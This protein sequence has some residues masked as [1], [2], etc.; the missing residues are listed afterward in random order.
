MNEVDYKLY[1]NIVA[2]SLEEIIMKTKNDRI[3]IKDFDS[4]DIYNKFVFQMGLIV[5]TVCND[6]YKYV[7]LDMNPIKYFFYCLR[8]KKY[9][10]LIKRKKELMVDDYEIDAKEFCK[11][12]CE[13]FNVS[14]SIIHDIYKEY[15]K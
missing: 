13:K 5:S 12:L 1:D 4:L 3:L 8:H 14:I 2:S 7:C 6:K 11:E 15:Y 10:L 9:K